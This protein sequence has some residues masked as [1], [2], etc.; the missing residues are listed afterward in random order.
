MRVYI[1]WSGQRSQMV[2]GILRDWLKK[3]I[4]S[5]EA[6]LPEHDV[7]NRPRPGEVT[8][9]MVK[10]AAVGILC[11]TPENKDRAA[12]SFEAGA[13]SAAIGEKF[14]CPWLLG[15][16]PSE[17]SGPLARF[18]ARKAD[19]EGTLA[20]I[21]TINAHPD[22]KAKL[23]DSDLNES[24]AVWWPRLEEQ[25]RRVP[26]LAGKP[27]DDRPIFQMT[28]EI[29][30][31][32]RELKQRP[33]SAAAQP[34]AAPAPAAPTAAA[35]SGRSML[36]QLIEQG[37]VLPPAPPKEALLAAEQLAPGRL[38][39]SLQDKDVLALSVAY[40]VHGQFAEGVQA[41]AV[42]L[43]CTKLGARGLLEQVRNVLAQTGMKLP[44]EQPEE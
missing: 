17:L 38:I 43:G 32:V 6:G 42:M 4:Q 22:L 31:I 36:R 3:M 16:E 41:L 27:A 39:F 19:R 7:E 15:V 20:L 11:L 10:Q 18:Q 29:L 25:L 24:F 14:I 30:Q 1:S 33:S 21:H 40:V 44:E 35:A 2:A 26:A 8:A 28:S 34:Q 13:M 12:V 9:A 23:S 37:I 5:V